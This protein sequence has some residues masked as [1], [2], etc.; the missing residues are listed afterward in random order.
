MKNFFSVI[1]KPGIEF[2]PFWGVLSR[3]IR[4]STVVINKIAI[5]LP[6]SQDGAYQMPSSTSHVEAT[7]RCSFE[8]AANANCLCNLS[9]FGRPPIRGT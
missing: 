5:P 7:I 4:N 6:S 8:R 2:V 3:A 1:R 9:T